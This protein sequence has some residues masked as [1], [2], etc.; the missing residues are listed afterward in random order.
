MSTMKARGEDM[1]ARS[2]RPTFAAALLAA[3]CIAPVAGAAQDPEAHAEITGVVVDVDGGAGIADVILR[4]DGTLVSAASD[5]SGRF[6]LR[7]IP[8]GTWTLRVEHVAYGEHEH[9]IAV[10]AGGQSRVQI[11]LAQEAIEMEPLVVEGETSLQRQRRATGASFWE[12][13]RERIVRAIGTS[14]HMGDVLRQVVPGLRLRQASNLTQTDVC[15]EFRGAASI[16]IV[17]ARP[18]NH[19]MV[20][21]D[22]VIVTNPQYLYGSV[23]MENLERIQVIP[24]G[25]AGARYGT[26]SLYGVILIETQRPGPIRTGPD[27]R[28]LLV[29]R[30]ALTFDWSRDPAGHDTDRAFLGALVG[31]AVGLT[32]GLLL[33]RQCIRVDGD[34]E[35]ATSCGATTNVLAGLSAFAL[36]AAGSALGVRWAGGTE[37]SVGRIV[38]AVLGAGMMLF[39]GYA[40]SMSTVGGD[41]PVVNRVGHTFLALGV[42]L[43]VTLADRLFRT[44]RQ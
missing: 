27:A 11:R 30:T 37:L 36:P 28:D 33:S 8:A 10:E 7:D 25:E 19:P 42:P 34:D 43:A 32:L 23:G 44:L 17:N 26:G 29:D 12:V 5:E 18:C 38:P 22:G 2:S 39:P 24:P 15:L 41:R 9:V 35:I 16:S 40:F 13:D 21:L 3:C 14:R 1:S 31:N 20:L 4:I 6:V